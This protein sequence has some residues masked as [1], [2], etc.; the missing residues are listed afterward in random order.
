MLKN[1]S[2][3]TEEENVR[4]SMGEEMDLRTERGRGSCSAEP[5]VLG[6][7]VLLWAVSFKSPK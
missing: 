7:Q 3:L 1:V 6:A 4:N 5:W 2:E